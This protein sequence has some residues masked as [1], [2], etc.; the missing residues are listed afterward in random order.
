ME[1]DVAVAGHEA[2]LFRDAEETNRT[3]NTVWQDADL[4]LDVRGDAFS[5][6]ADYEAVLDRVVGVS[7]DTWF[8]AL[9]DDTVFATERADVIADMLADLPAPDGFDA[10]AIADDDVT[11]GRYHVVAAVSQYVLCAWTDEWIAATESGDEAAAEAAAEAITSAHDWPILGEIDNQGS[12]SE[13]MWAG[14]DVFAQGMSVSEVAELYGSKE[15]AADP[16]PG[17]E[18]YRA[19]FGCNQ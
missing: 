19:V 3:Y 12:W 6:Q 14:A 7:Q 10:S 4:T 13:S 8:T 1:K 2:I 16:A 9:P 11:V 15:Q 18:V 17:L 5:D